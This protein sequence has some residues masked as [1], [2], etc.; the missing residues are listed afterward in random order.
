M[1]SVNKIDNYKKEV[2]RQGINR[3]T[4]KWSW[5]TQ[6]AVLLIDYVK[7]GLHC[8]FAALVIL[9]MDHTVCPHLDCCSTVEAE[10]VKCQFT[11]RRYCSPEGRRLITHNAILKVISIRIPSE[12]VQYH[13]V[14]GQENKQLQSC[15]LWAGKQTAA[16]VLSVSRKTNSCS[17]AACGP[18]LTW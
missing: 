7:D 6:C 8:S 9:R 17:H 18:L 10:F 12:E 15:C 5:I 14:C 2:N 1:A 16:V 11:S 4:R 3:T 13:T